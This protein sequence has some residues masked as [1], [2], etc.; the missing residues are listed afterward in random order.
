MLT[1]PASARLFDEAFGRWL[2]EQLANPPEGIRRALR[3]ST[4]SGDNGP[5]DRLRSAAWELAQWRDFTTPWTREP[6][7]RRSEMSRLITSLHEF[8]DL[9][10]NPQS[11]NDPLHT[12]TEPARRLSDEISVH[13]GFGDG[14]ATALMD[15]WEAALVDLSRDRLL[16]TVRQGRGTAFSDRVPRQHVLQALADLRAR[17]D[18]F[19][20]AA[21][22]DLAALL[23]GELQGAIRRYESTKAAAGAL[24]FLDLLLGARNLIRDNPDVRR[25][26]QQRFKR[27]FVDEFQD[28]DPLQAEI[29]LLL[30]ADD[31]RETN[32]RRAKPAAGRLFL[33]GDPKQS[34][35]RF[36]RADVAV[37]RDVCRQLESQ[38]ATIVRLNTS[39]RSVP[40]IQTCVNTAFAP[41][42]TGDDLTLQADYVPLAPLSAG[43]C[44]STGD[45]GAASARTLCQALHLCGIDRKIAARR[46]GRARRLDRPSERLDGDRA[47][48]YG[49]STGGGKARVPA[50]QAIHQLS[51]GRDARL[52]RRLGVARAAARSRGRPRVSRA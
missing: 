38:G 37:Y 6:F 36:R 13:Q 10:R 1:E 43:D 19:R 29:L 48:R 33:V 21:D 30:A 51:D 17:L 8:A 34:I 40:A 20:M 32:W 23:Q 7:D 24:D 25:G 3:R 46:D 52:R 49:A 26:F 45:R 9:T 28:T 18:Q 12:G 50:L 4:F 42:M 41:I 5:V 44:R 31:D 2:Q 27:I 47:Q 16:A 35:Y 15:Q 39:F 11:R 22:A 14:I